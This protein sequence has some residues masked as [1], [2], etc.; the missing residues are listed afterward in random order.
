MTPTANLEI[1]WLLGAVV[2]EKHFTNDKTLPGNDHYHVADKADLVG[3]RRRI[4]RTLTVMGSDPW[5]RTSEI[6]AIR[7]AR[8]GL[9]TR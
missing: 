9:V 1:A 4:Y 3:L 2:L 6:D 5:D 7:Y 8:R